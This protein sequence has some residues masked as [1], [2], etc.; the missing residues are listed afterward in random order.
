MSGPQLDGRESNDRQFRGR[1]PMDRHLAEGQFKQ[2]VYGQIGDMLSALAEPRRLEMLEL[3]SQCERNVESLAELLG[4]GMTTVSHHL[5]VLKR[6]RL[7]QDRKEGR[8]VYYS[9]SRLALM[10]WST[11]SRIASSELSEVKYAIDSLVAEDPNTGSTTRETIDY[12]ELLR[13][14]ER[15][16]AVLIDVRPEEEFAAGHLPGAMSVS[17][18]KL[19]QKAKELPRDKPIYAYCRGRY[20]VLSHEASRILAEKG[21]SVTPLPDGVAEWKAADVQLEASTSR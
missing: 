11:V 19:E 20:C 2:I 16:E 13:R 6:A 15:G 12:D 8:R 17:L 18:E 9:A 3:L 4:A 7:V 10:L 1:E 14:I 21:Y 5:Q